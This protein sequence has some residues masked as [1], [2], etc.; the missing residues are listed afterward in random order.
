M[1]VP[2]KPAIYLISRSDVNFR[3]IEQFDHVEV[4]I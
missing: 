2:S 1:H 4:F 3:Q